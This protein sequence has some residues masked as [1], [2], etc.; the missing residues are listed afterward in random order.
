M[1]CLHLL[2]Q[3]E[4]IGTYTD[5][6]STE[7]CLIVLQFQRSFRWQKPQ[8]VELVLVLPIYTRVSIRQKENSRLGYGWA[9]LRQRTRMNGSTEDC[10]VGQTSQTSEHSCQEK[11]L[12]MCTPCHEGLEVPGARDHDK[13]VQ[14]AFQSLP[15]AGVPLLYTRRFEHARLEAMDEAPA[16]GAMLS[17]I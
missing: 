1:M 4:I 15:H 14:L 17:L 2:L 7:P 3:Q 5:L 12:R 9:W 10:H 16:I 8:P 13:I 6:E 11:L